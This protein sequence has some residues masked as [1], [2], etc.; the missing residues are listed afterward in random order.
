MKTSG[1]VMFAIIAVITAV[2][3]PIQASK[4]EQ[5]I[6]QV[7]LRLKSGPVLNG[8][9]VK[10]DQMSIDFTVK[11]I[12]QSVPCD[13]LIG[14]MFIPPTVR[15]TPMPTPTPCPPSIDDPIIYSMTAQVKPT[16]LHRE[17]ANYTVK[18]RDEKIQGT[19]VLQVVFDKNGRITN[20]IPIR[21]LPYGLTEQAIGTAYRIRFT[22][23]MKDGQPVSVRG[24]L[25]FTFNLY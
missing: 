1:R 2:S 24:S 21:E 4:Q 25:E 5:K 17:K 19:V 9:L 7:W 16:I 20:V 22:P 13:D 18:A 11:G 12:L 10:M 15:P 8:N 6:R 3:L 23:A 14:V